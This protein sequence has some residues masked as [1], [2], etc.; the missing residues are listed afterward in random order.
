MGEYR[1]MGVWAC[2]RIGARVDS[3][4]EWTYGTHGTYGPAH[5]GRIKSHQVA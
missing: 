3:A 5:I 2:G 1:R 4:T